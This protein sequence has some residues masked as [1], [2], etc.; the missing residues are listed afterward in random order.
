MHVPDLEVMMASDGRKTGGVFGFFSSLRKTLE[1][2][3][4][5][6]KVVVAWDTNRSK[7]RIELLPEYKGN[8]NP[9]DEEEAKEMERYNISFQSQL[10]LIQRNLIS[11]GIRQ[12]ALPNREGDDII[13]LVC[14]LFPDQAKVVVSDDK[15]LIQLVGCTTSVFRPFKEEEINLENFEEKTGAVDRMRF[16]TAKAIL[17]DKSDNISG[18]E[19]VGEKTVKDLLKIVNKTPADM[20]EDHVLVFE[21]ACHQMPQTKKKQMKARYAK[22]VDGL[23]VIRRNMEL[24]NLSKEDFSEEEEKAAQY[25]VEGGV[26]RFNRQAAIGFFTDLEF[27]SMIKYFSTFDKVLSPLS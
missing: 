5:S 18:V 19:G 14:R 12:V 16:I 17:G 6:S 21:A 26:V 10:A 27:N 3:Q 7:R 25:Y 1:A 8:R 20:I 13:G 11:F 23:D 22:V 9:K 2:Y 4:N 15:D 24:I